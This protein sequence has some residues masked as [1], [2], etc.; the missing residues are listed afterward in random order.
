MIMNPFSKIIDSIVLVASIA[1]YRTHSPGSKLKENGL[2]YYQTIPN[3]TI[4]PK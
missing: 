1:F 2:D 4:L 3:C